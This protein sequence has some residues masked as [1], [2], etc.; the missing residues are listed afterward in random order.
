ML[1]LRLW[2]LL[3]VDFDGAR[4]GAGVGTAV[5]VVVTRVATAPVV[6]F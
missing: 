3:V 5:A 1:Y 2:H 4:G 6:D